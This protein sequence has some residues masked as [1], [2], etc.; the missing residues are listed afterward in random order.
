MKLIERYEHNRIRNKIKSIID[1]SKTNY[2]SRLFIQNCNNLSR[3]WELI[4]QLSNYGKNRSSSIDKIISSNI[5]YANN[6]DI[7]EEF[8]NYFSGVASG[9]RDHIAPSSTNPISYIR[10][11]NLNSMYLAPTTIQECETLIKNSKNTKT[12]TNEIPVTL[13]KE[14]GG[15]IA[16][17]LCKIINLCFSTGIFPECLK[18]GTITPIFKSGD[19][20]EVKTQLKI[21]AESRQR[22]K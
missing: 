19:R 14:I 10:P 6:A 4:K 17:C 18:R 20:C 2:F 7:A 21:G 22:F 1:K 9:L 11:N 15:K 12:G 3:T 5:E 13:I 16:P 8:S